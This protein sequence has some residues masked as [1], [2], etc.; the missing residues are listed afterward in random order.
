MVDTFSFIDL[1]PLDITN[2]A[3]L[4]KH[5]DG[6][7]MSKLKPNR[8]AK[9][10]APMD[11]LLF[12]IDS[13]AFSGA[14]VGDDGTDLNA[15]LDPTPIGPHGVKVVDEV[16]LTD[17]AWDGDCS[18][19]DCLRPLMKRQADEMY[20][21]D[22]DDSNNNN[23]NNNNS[24]NQSIPG[25][26]PAP[27]PIRPTSNKRQRRNSDDLASE[28]TQPTSKVQCNKLQIRAHQTEQ[29][30]ERYGELVE[31]REEHGHCVV[32]Y[33]F[34]RNL[35]LALWVMLGWGELGAV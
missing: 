30:C 29:W 8:P 34:K 26:I 15:S 28:D 21:N 18:V 10:I 33:H 31:F 35:S 12:S 2:E 25:N 7:Y 9:A 6:V 13:S 14:D 11:S 22:N 1:Y 19:I 27:D 20:F 23:N 3:P 32:P 5:L 4:S 16:P 17:I 24:P